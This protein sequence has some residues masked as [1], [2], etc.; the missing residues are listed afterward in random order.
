MTGAAV[1]AAYI[2]FKDGRTKSMNH[3]QGLNL[4][5]YF[6]KSGSSPQ[7][8]LAR[9]IDNAKETIDVAVYYITK[10]K[11]VTHLCNATKRGVRVRIV[12]D[13]DN[14]YQESAL[15]KL[16]ESGI[17]IKINTYGGKMHLKN[18]IIDKKIISTGSYNFTYS[19]EVQNEEIVIISDDNK[20]ATE[21]SIKFDQMWNDTINYTSYKPRDIRKHA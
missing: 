14:K 7:K 2:Y 8:E 15:N 3:E 10:T 11:I 19:A 21:W 17:P 6:S 4:K 16:L 20:I 9:I 13:Q 5:Y 1:S 18:M 12:T